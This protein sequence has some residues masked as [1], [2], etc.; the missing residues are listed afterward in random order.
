MLSLQVR[1]Q[2]AMQMMLP[3]IHGRVNLSTTTT[4]SNVRCGPKRERE[5]GAERI[6][7]YQHLLL[8]DEVHDC[9]LLAIGAKILQ[10]LDQHFGGAHELKVF[11]QLCQSPV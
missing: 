4:N 2:K 11:V 5:R 1:E 8:A 7:E 6:N 9:F 10:E 3:L